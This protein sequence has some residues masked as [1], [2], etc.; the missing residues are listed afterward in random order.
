M[1]LIQLAALCAFVA[2]VHAPGDSRQPRVNQPPNMAPV[3]KLRAAD[4]AGEPAARISIG[5]DPLEWIKPER[6]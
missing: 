2:P 5:I 3:G 6:Y 1:N 4:G